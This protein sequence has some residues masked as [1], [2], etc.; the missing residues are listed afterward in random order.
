MLQDI[1]DRLTGKFAFGMLALIVVPFMFFGINSDFIGQGYAAK[2]D[3]GEISVNAFENAYRNAM[4]RYTDQGVDVPPEFRRIIREGVLDSLIR[5]RLL[6]NYVANEGF[7]INDSMVTSYIQ[8]SSAFQVDGAFSKEA[9]FQWLELRATNPADFESSQRVGLRLGQ[10]QRGVAAT[11]F[12]TPSEYRRYLNLYG[13]Q[14]R[15]S[16]VEFD[17]AGLAASVE[18][19]DEDIALY[20]DTRP[21][22]FLTPETVDLNYVE[23]R[24]DDLGPRAEVSEEELQRYYEESS[25]LY[26][27]DERRQARHILILFDDD[28]IKAEEQATELGARA[29][30]GEPF[31]D[32]ARQYSKDGGTAEQG[33]DLSMLLQTQLPGVL[34]DTIFS[35]EQG[36]IAGPV[37]SNFGF[38]II[39]LDGIETGGTLPFEQV[40]AQITDELRTRKAIEIFDD[41][42]QRLSNALFD[43]DEMPAMAENVGIE[44]KTASGYGRAGGEPFGAN[45]AMIDAVFDDR[46]L[47]ERQISDIIELDANRSVVFQVSGHAVAA[48]QPMDEVLEELTAAIQSERGAEMASELANQLEAA[49]LLGDDVAVAAVDIA[50]AEVN[51]MVVGRQDTEID[52]RLLA[53]IFQVRKPNAET[54]SVGI[55]ITQ[56]GNY[57]VFTVSSYAPGRPEAIPLAERDAGKIRLSTQSGSADYA[58]LMADLERNAVITKS[59]DALAQQSIFE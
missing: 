2:V 46:N 56:A 50:H 55:I 40:R 8:R 11:A 32:L 29:R 23:I 17:V 36:D 51:E 47:V 15:A 6:D 48:R 5:Q 13:E 49:L 53:A 43:A 19:S 42:E 38:H 12:V 39:R 27:Q 16:Y 21:D 18:V 4:L 31:E 20:Y 14:R 57:S 1:R 44:L 26:L 24:R 58:A 34:G 9:Y 33:G 7:R 35:M 25:S 22:S 37:R 3:G 10:L 45:Q 41:L 54:P 28:E 59:E 52:S 30:A